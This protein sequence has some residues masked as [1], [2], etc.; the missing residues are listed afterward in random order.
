MD[1]WEK[2]IALLMEVG[3]DRV[4]SGKQR[5]R[6]VNGRNVPGFVT[7][8]RL[9]ALE[10]FEHSPGDLWVTTYPKSGTTWCQYVVYLLAGNTPDW[11]YFSQVAWLEVGL[12][13]D[14]DFASLP[15]PQAGRLRLFKSHW[16][17]DCHMAYNGKSRY[18]YIMRNGLDVAVSYFHH[19]YALRM[20]EYD[21]SLDDYFELFM[22]GDV[23]CG[24]WW[25]HCLAWWERSKR[26]GDVLFIH[27]E[28]MK[29][30][31]VAVYRRIAEFMGVSATDEELQKIKSLTTVSAMKKL[32]EEAPGHKR[33]AQAARKPDGA[34]HIR[35]G[36]VGESKQCLS[37]EQ[38]ARF[39]AKC[40]VEFAD[41]D[42]P[43]RRHLP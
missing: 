6:V 18:I 38:R 15:P 9:A 41:S 19:T 31:T 32:A 8:E 22:E 23:D 5:L 21:G 11:K 26:H 3:R 13:M 40:E 29:S 17:P 14:V 24:S 2:D 4:A 33:L 43:W 25:R 12:L 10:S 30:D 39:V 35:N 1:K 28:D 34:S 42:I 36:N 7:A 37:A 20:Y 16:W 27:Y